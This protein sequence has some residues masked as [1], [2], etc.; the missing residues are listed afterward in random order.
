[1]EFSNNTP[2]R[3]M[4]KPIFVSHDITKLHAPSFAG[5]AEVMKGICGCRIPSLLNAALPDNK[6]R[7]LAAADIGNEGAD[8]GSVGLA[9]RSSEDFG[10]TWDNPREILRLAAHR[11]PQGFDDWTSPFTID[12][13]LMQAP[14]GSV[15]A[16]VDLWPECKGLGRGDWLE[17]VTGYAEV[18]GKRYLA[19][20][21]EPS[22]LG[23]DG[24]HEVKLGA[25]YTVRENGWV[26][27]PD[28]SRTRYYMPQHHSSEDKFM[29]LGD[30]Y[31]AV[32]EGEYIHAI[33]P[34]MPPLPDGHRDIY[35]GNVFISLEKP[36]FNPDSPVYVSKRRAGPM[37]TANGFDVT[38]NYE[39]IETDPAPLRCAITEFLYM[40]RS[41]DGG[42]SWGEPEDISIYVKEACDGAFLGVGPGVGIKLQNQENH[43]KNGRLLLPLYNATDI[44]LRAGIAYS[45]DSGC[46]WHRGGAIQNRDEVQFVELQKGE[47][48]AFGRKG[49]GWSEGAGPTPVSKSLDGGESWFLEPETSLMSVRCQKSFTH[50]PVD[51]G[52]NPNSPYRYPKG[53]TPGKEYILASHPTGLSSIPDCK[54]TDGAISL[55]EVQEDGSVKWIKRRIVTV[56]GQYADAN[57][58]KWRK[59]FAYSCLS[60]LEDGSLG[61]LYEPQPSNYIA[62][63][64]FSL[65]WILAEEE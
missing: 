52:L 18:D 41:T 61:I 39:I 12:P 59:F 15:L 2:F 29:T 38:S 4:D 58:E 7:L 48:L 60:V 6:F 56:P 47:I 26:Y 3:T 14:D 50:Y 65:E 23:S 13:V 8:W 28:G 40:L 36:A 16:V 54:R 11:A 46:T 21:D 53:M 30:L 63:F 55:G 42:K 49:G 19:L 37:G 57:E 45:D 5:D 62:F 24:K 32:G 9:I 33:P 64:R 34:L 10:E 27:A 44:D 35:V 1:M 22:L 17:N 25:P 20:Y 43:S 51:D 31:Y